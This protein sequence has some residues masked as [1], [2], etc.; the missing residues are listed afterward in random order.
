MK[1]PRKPVKEGLDFVRDADWNPVVRTR[2]GA[3]ALGRKM[4]GAFEK[5][6]GFVPVV[7]DCGAYFRISFGKPEPRR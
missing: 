1:N 2:Q 7:C 5:R 3:L 6:Y 4:R